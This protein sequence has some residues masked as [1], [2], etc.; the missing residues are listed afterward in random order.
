MNSR[1][2]LTF[3]ALESRENPSGPTV[4][5]P[6]VITPPTTDT[7]ITAPAE[8]ISNTAGDIGAAIINGATGGSSGYMNDV[9]GI[10]KI[11]L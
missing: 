11:P 3:L 2:R 1:T 8:T 7:G 4:V 6:I 10:Y 5:E 9:N